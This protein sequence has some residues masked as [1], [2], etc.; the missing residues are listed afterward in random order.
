[1]T[2]YFGLLDVGE[3][4]GRAR[5]SSCPA[6]RARSAASSARS[7]RSRAAAS[8]ASPAGRRS[9]R[10]WSTSSASTPRSTTRPRTSRK[11]LRAACPDGI[12][13]YF[14]NVGGDDPRRRA[15]APGAAAPASSSAARSRQY[16]ATE[17]H[18]RPVELPV[19]AG[20]P[21][22]AWTGLVVFDYAARYREARGGDRRLDGRRAGSTSRSSRRGTI[23]D[24]PATLQHAVPRREH[25]QARP[26]TG[27]MMDLTFSER[28]LEFREELRAWLQDNHPGDEPDGRRRR[29]LRLAARLAAPPRRGRLGRRPLADRVRR[30]RRDADRVG[31]LL[32]GARPRRRA[33]AGQRAR[34]AARRPDD[35]DVGHATSRRSATWRRS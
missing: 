32:R 14:D 20:Q 29:R 13:V 26:R 33:A 15:R 28:E 23:D 4:A 18:A 7:P 9:A 22:R 2:A 19:A 34:P 1:M 30:A 17:P 35:H 5:P 21:R 27:G 25:R 8:S 12:D 6:R 16:N 3:P 10:C 31:D 11:A 24:F